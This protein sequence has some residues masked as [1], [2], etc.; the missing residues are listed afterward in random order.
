MQLTIA[1]WKISRTWWVPEQILIKKFAEQLSPILL[2]VFVVIS[3][4]LSSLW[5][6]SK[7]FSLLY[8]INLK[9]HRL[10]LHPI[11][12]LNVNSKILYKMLACRLEEV[13]LSITADDQI[14]YTKCSHSFFNIRRQLNLLYGPTPPDIPEILPSLGLG[15]IAIF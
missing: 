10:Q 5:L 13:L 8:L 3:S 4:L 1:N 6:F 2:S 15:N 7:Q 11:S 9:P 12:V 14:G